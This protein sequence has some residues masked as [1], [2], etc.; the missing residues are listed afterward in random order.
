M[1]P[2]VKTVLIIIVLIFVGGVSGYFYHQTDTGK[3][4]L[5]QY[6]PNLFQ[7]SYN[8]ILSRQPLVQ[9]YT[10]P[11]FGFRL[12]LNQAW[13][14]YRVFSEAEKGDVVS[15]YL[16]VKTNDPAWTVDVAGYA[17]PLYL[18]V[19][20]QAEW[21]ALSAMSNEQNRFQLWG[22]KDNYVVVAETWLNAPTDLAQQ[23]FGF[24]AIKESFQW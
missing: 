13:Q 15:Y 20:S 5:S 23:D 17:C 11:D 18:S 21:Q 2:Y 14:N 6:Q 7:P 19:L 9:Q 12:L 8:R 4:S 22:T 16:C 3:N 10:N 24:S 1:N